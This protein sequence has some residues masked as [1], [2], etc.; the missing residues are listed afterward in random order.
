MSVKMK[1]R[2]MEKKR[3]KKSE[4]KRKSGGLFLAAFIVAAGVFAIMTYMQKEALSDYE[5]KD[6]LVACT[7]IPRGVVINEANADE[8]LMIKSIDAGCIPDGA[9]TKDTML[10]G[11]SPVYEISEGT[12]LTA[13]MFVAPDHAIASLSEPVLAGFRT[14]DLS[15]AVSGVLRAGDLIDIYSS[16]PETGEGILLC[17][18]AYVERGYDSSGNEVTSDTPAVMFNI[19]LEYSEAEKFY[20]GMKNGSLYV[21]KECADMS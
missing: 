6:I 17:H 19:Y 8:Y 20:E 5:K 16:D 1:G 12:L 21:V 2:K 3:S 7:V 9:V 14:D 4:D 18:N 13:S 15:R 10:N 11:M